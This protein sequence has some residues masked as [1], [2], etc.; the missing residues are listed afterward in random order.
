MDCLWNLSRKKEISYFTFP[1]A[2]W[3]RHR[4]KV[5]SEHKEV[6]RSVRQL[7]ESSFSDVFLLV[8]NLAFAVKPAVRGK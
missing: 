6:G 3:S 7:V 4:C 8:A 2:L 1:T 5:I